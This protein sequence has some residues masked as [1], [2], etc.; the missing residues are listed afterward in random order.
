MFLIVILLQPWQ[1]FN[2]PLGGRLLVADV[3]FYAQ[4]VLY[5]GP[6]DRGCQ[7]DAFQ[8]AAPAQRHVYLSAGKRVAGINNSVFEGEALALVYR[9]GPGEPK[10]NLRERPL[11]IG[12]DLVFLVELVFRV[13]PGLRLHGD[14]TI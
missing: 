12:H 5:H 11:D 8:C 3:A 6:C 10:G 13:L 14:E 9:D 1:V 2:A 4:V 7:H